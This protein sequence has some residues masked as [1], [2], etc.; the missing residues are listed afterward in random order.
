[1]NSASSRFPRALLT[2]D[3]TRSCQWRLRFT[4]HSGQGHQDT[5]KSPAV[6][7]L[8]TATRRSSKTAVGTATNLS[9]LQRTAPSPRHTRGTSFSG[10]NVFGICSGTPSN[11][12]TCPF[13]CGKT[14]ARPNKLHRASDGRKPSQELQCLLHGR[15]LIFRAQ[16]DE[17]GSHPPNL[18]L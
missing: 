1:V 15:T 14:A 13:L 9:L 16:S 3:L 8:Q 4:Y 5:Q 17:S 12:G 7:E 2:H 6:W 10:A 11:V 18:L